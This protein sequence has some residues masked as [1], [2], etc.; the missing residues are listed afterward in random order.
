MVAIKSHSSARCVS[1]V[2][3]NDATKEVAMPQKAIGVGF[4]C[5]LSRYRSLTLKQ[6]REVGHQTLPQQTGDQL[7]THIRWVV[8]ECTT[9]KGP[10]PSRPPLM[11]WA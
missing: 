8:E 3:V 6:V 4:I 9:T 2:S 10:S 7:K 1:F 5:R 11:V